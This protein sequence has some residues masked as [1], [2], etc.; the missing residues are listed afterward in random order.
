MGQS[1][2]NLEC[3]TEYFEL[4][5]ESTVK[6]FELENVSEIFHFREYITSHLM[7]RNLIS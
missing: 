3:Q 2:S 5:S 7:E 1:M 6:I 4:H